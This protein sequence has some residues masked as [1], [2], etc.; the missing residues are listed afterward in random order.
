M[1]T[2]RR[3]RLGSGCWGQKYITMRPYVIVLLLRICS[4]SSGVKNWSRLSSFIQFGALDQ[5]IIIHMRFVVG[6]Y[7]LAIKCGPCEDNC[8][9]LDQ[10]LYWWDTIG[11]VGGVEIVLLQ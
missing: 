10:V 3:I 9:V 6:L 2:V 11:V 7:M 4:N 5:Y 1:P 8:H